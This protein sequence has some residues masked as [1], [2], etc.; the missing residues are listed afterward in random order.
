MKYSIIIPTYKRPDKLIRSIRSVLGQ[1]HDNYEIICVNDSPDYEYSDFD[2]FL[3]NIEHNYR[4]KIKYYINTKNSGVN[5]TRNMALSK[6]SDDSNYIIFLDDD[7]WL[8][9]DALIDIDTYLGRNKDIKWL[10]T[11]RYSANKEMTKNI[12]N[13]DKLS[14]FFDYLIFKNFSGDCTHILKSNIAKRIKFSNKIK[15][16]EEWFYFIQI[17]TYMTYKNF[18][19]TESD[20]YENG[21]LN[22]GMQAIYNS[23]TFILWTELNSF[24]MFMYMILRTIYVI[25]K[26]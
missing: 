21:G 3:K 14:Y 2:F 23:N 18:N 20:G 7:D 10:V 11:N 8:S 4:N 1:A 9:K 15:N 19:T 5:F 22:Q 24:N 16:G 17:S 6:I 12:N 13:K 26:K 25:I